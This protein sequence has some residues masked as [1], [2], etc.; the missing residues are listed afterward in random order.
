MFVILILRLFNL[1][2]TLSL[3]RRCVRSNCR[4]SI[5]DGTSLCARSSRLQR[6]LQTSTS[7]IFLASIVVVTVIGG[8]AG[9]GLC[10]IGLGLGHCRCRCRCLCL[11]QS[12]S[13]NASKQLFGQSVIAI[14]KG[15]G[16]HGL[17]R[18]NILGQVRKQVSLIGNQ[19]R[20]EMCLQ[21]CTCL[22]TCEKSSH[23]TNWKSKRT[24]T[25]KKR[26]YNYDNTHKTLRPWWPWPPHSWNGNSPSRQQ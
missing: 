17:V 22:Q 19:C 21:S 5:S 8:L 3:S 10:G 15:Q 23:I 26:Y 7:T 2:C 24:M 12:R 4:Q 20:C 16:R 11:C 9:G 6:H 13:G 1:Q 25:E 18:I 14:N